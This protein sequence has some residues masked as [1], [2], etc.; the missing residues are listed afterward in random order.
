MD[1][2]YDP[3]DAIINRINLQLARSRSI[4][5]SWRPQNSQPEDEDD[6][7][8]QNNDDF[9]SFG[10]KG[11]VGSKVIDNEESALP[12]R[13]STPKEKL[14]EQL[15]GK[16]AANAKRKED[17][18]KSMSVSKHAAPKPITSVTKKPKQEESDEE[19]EGRAAAFKSKRSGKP[20]RQERAAG[21]V[22]VDSLGEDKDE[23]DGDAVESG[24]RE[25]QAQATTAARPEWKS[26]KRKAGGSY[27]DELLSQKAKKK[28]K[29]KQKG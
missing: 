7:P 23:V 10:E 28:G 17:A 16:K 3:N 13:R 1:G 12:I 2:T 15:I 29:K 5:N 9:A 20:K 8:E 22:S 11:G 14:L 18:H 6:E 25:V 27:L 24:S 19:E 21:D 26:Q 4:L